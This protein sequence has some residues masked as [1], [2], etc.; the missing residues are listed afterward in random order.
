MNTV[1]KR[2]VI[3]KAT[4]TFFACF[5]IRQGGKSGT[6]RKRGRDVVVVKGP[7][8]AR[9]KSP[10]VPKSATILC[11]RPPYRLPEG[12]FRK[13]RPAR[14]D[15]FLVFPGG[16]TGD[17]SRTA[18]ERRSPRVLREDEGLGTRATQPPV[19][20]CPEVERW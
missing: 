10:N 5:P 18:A 19:A 9:R 7:S 15:I 8:F 14:D 13:Q 16:L 11:A 12:F 2:S 6:A 20:G 17:A 1:E 4:R 3:L